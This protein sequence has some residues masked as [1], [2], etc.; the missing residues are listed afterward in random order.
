MCKPT[1]DWTLFNF[2]SD[3]GVARTTFMDKMCR[4]SDCDITAVKELL[5]DLS[6]YHLRYFDLTHSRI[7]QERA[8]QAENAVGGQNCISS[9]TNSKN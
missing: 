4:L 8:I 9:I 3:M 6:V 1:R 5:S 7:A 2:S